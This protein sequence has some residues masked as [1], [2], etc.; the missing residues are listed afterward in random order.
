MVR[1]QLLRRSGYR[2]S[3]EVC[4]RTGNRA[5]CVDRAGDRADAVGRTVDQTGDWANRVEG[6]GDRAGRSK[7]TCD[8]TEGAKRTRDITSN[9]ALGTQNSPKTRPMFK[10][11]TDLDSA[12]QTKRTSKPDF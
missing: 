8:G 1:G 5:D 7:G 2:S 11:R 9:L 4:T 6:A 10:I 3:E 12:R